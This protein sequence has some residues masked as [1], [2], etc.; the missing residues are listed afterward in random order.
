[1]FSISVDW[2][3]YYNKGWENKGRDLI[4]ENCKHKDKSQDDTNMR[5]SGAC[6][7]CGFCEDSC[8]PM[9][10]YAYPLETTPD[11][12][13][14]IEVC[15]R[16]NCTVMYKD[17]EDAYYLALCGGGMNLSQD[18][19]LAYNILEK[20]IPLDLALKV[21][22]QDGLSQGGKDF[23]QV[24]RACKDS[25]KIDIN[26]GKQRIKAIREAIK[27]SLIKKD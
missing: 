13:E 5:Y 1:M 27:K 22:T 24:M 23:R 7:K 12:E 14:I 9:M 20:W 16:T 10:N 3:D 21:S 19:A 8:E 4:I 6:E 25:I 11:D 15:K 2:Q 17:D 26:N 18:I